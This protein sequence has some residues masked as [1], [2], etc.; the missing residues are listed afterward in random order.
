MAAVRKTVAAEGRL[1]SAA[2]QEGHAAGVEV[3]RTAGWH[4][5]RCLLHCAAL[6]AEERSYPETVAVEAASKG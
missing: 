3:Q 1:A 5:S 2:R 6:V 4:D